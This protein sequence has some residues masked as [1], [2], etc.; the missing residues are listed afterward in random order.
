MSKNT[1][2]IMGIMPF[3]VPLFLIFLTIGLTPWFNWY[4]NALSDLGNPEI[5][6]YAP[7]FNFGLC[8]GGYLMGVCTL[9]YFRK[10]SIASQL[11][12]LLMG[13]SLILI[14]AFNETYDKFFKLHFI[15]SFTFFFTLLLFLIAYSIEKRTP[16]AIPTIIVGILIWIFHLKYRVPKGAAIPEIVSVFLV[17][18]YYIAY[19]KETLGK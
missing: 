9:K 2:L 12:L 8:I 10:R 11:I 16:A 13:F 14:G 19:L 17:I 18:P 5:S 4:Y 6:S 7:I 15:V 3:I 1:S